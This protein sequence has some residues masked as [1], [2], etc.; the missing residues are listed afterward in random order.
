[1]RTVRGRMSQGRW[2]KA[3]WGSACWSTHKTTSMCWPNHATPPSPVPTTT[4]SR[5]A[6]DLW[7]LTMC[8]HSSLEP[9]AGS[10]LSHKWEIIFCMYLFAQDLV[11]VVMLS[12]PCGWLCTLMRLPPMFGYIICGVLL[13]PSG[14]NSIKVSDES[15]QMHVC[16]LHDLS[17]TCMWCYVFC[18][19]CSLWFRWK[20]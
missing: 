17:W 15:L 8:S 11:Y 20:H 5:S 6:P 12:L 9:I 13:G 4:S 16:T 10:A 1:M 2:T 7:P 14:L 18:S 3:I 19:A